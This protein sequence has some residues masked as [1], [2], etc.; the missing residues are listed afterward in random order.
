MERDSQQGLLREQLEHDR[1]MRIIDRLHDLIVQGAKGLRK[2]K[3]SAS[4][5]VFVFEF[6]C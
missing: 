2:L 5:Y 1:R 4:H 6:S 3:G